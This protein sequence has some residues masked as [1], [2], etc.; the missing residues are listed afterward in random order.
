M[1]VNV[2]FFSILVSIVGMIYLSYGRKQNLYFFMSGIILVI[3]PYFVTSLVWLLIIAIVL[4]FLPFLL[5][6]RMPL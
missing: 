1:D 3:Y 6:W 5:N 2:L 4:I